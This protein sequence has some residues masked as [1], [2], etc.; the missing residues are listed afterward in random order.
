LRN[1]G[2]TLD[3]VAKIKEIQRRGYETNAKLNEYWMEQLTSSL[4]ADL[5]PSDVLRYPEFIESLTPAM[6]QEA[7]RKYL[8]TANYAH[9]TLL[10]Q[11]PDKA[12]P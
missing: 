7:A 6:I 12:S 11:A 10:P 9:F 1:V 8:N 3:D 5:D 4:S 2:P